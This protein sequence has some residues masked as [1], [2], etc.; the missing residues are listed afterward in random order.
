MATNQFTIYTATDINGPGPLTGT[1]GSLITLLDACLVNGYTGKP[2]A[3]W[4]K[5]I[6]N[7]GSVYGAW[8][9]GTGSG[10]TLFINDFQQAGAGGKEAW[11]VGW[12]TITQVESGTG[13][14]NVGAGFGQFPTPAQSLTTGH[15]PWRK[16]TTADTTPRYWI[17]AADAAT[18][19]LW[20]QTGDSSTNYVNYGF[21]DCYSLTGPSDLWNCFIYGRAADNSGQ[22]INSADF[23]DLIMGNSNGSSAYPSGLPGHYI[24]RSSFGNGTSIPVGRRGDATVSNTNVGNS[25]VWFS[26]AINGILQAP[27]GGDGCYYM[28]QLFITETVTNPVIRGRLRGLYQMCHQP[29]IFADGQIISGSNDFAGKTFMVIKQSA[30]TSMW[31][32]EI[33]PTLEFN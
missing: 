28:S 32:L 6:A 12:E 21:G 22:F 16:S 33:S 15:I 11:A 8:T 25:G 31:A 9:Q 13:S 4:T 1:T 2:A 29:S 20:I 23:S 19:Y 7:S 27:M 26:N 14:L 3:G 5:P 18:M 24:A 10:F 17:L 30:N